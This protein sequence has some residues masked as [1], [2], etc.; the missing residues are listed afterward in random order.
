MGKASRWIRNLLIGKKEEKYK[1]IDGGGS[2]IETQSPKVKRRWSFG[3]KSVKATKHSL[4]SSF[5]ITESAR[6]QIRA[7][8]Q[9][10]P[11]PYSHIQKA[12]AT[13][14]Q[15]AFRAYLGRKALRALRGL[16]KLQAL[17]R[18]HLVRK[19]TNTA[20]RGMH[21]LMTIQV[22]ARIHRILMAQQLQNETSQLKELKEMNMRES[23][24][25][26]RSRSAR[27]D[28]PYRKSREHDSRTVSSKHVSD[29]WVSKR[30]HQ[31]SAPNS[32]ADYL[33][34]S[35]LNPTEGL[36]TSLRHHQSYSCEPNYMTRTESSRAKARSE[37]EPKQRPKRGIRH[38]NNNQPIE[39]L[40]GRKQRSF[41]VHNKARNSI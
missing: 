28:G 7:I 37:S 13:K 16:V 25:V 1:Q 20:L 5:D 6:L 8:L 24:G 36:S 11:L 33:A 40:D 9:S 14:I 34:M 2:E 15:A 41:L 17:V 22:R 32:P 12:A 10:L 29:L 23:L 39:P 31:Y 3:K 26:T 30:R 4:S 38:I 19:Q 18:G 27:L 35:G 21:A